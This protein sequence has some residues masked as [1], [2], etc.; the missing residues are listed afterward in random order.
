MKLALSHVEKGDYAPALELLIDEWQ[1]TRRPSVADA[2]D[3]VDR[4]FNLPASK[5][6][7]WEADAAATTRAAERGPLIRAI[8]PRTTNE[9]LT[10]VDVAMKWD[11]PRVGSLIIALL[12]EL[13]YSG[14]RSKVFWDS[15]FRRIPKLRDARFAL[16][17]PTL[18]KTWQVGPS[19]QTWLTNRLKKAATFHVEDV[20][21]EVLERIVEVAQAQI[22]ALAVSIG[23]HAGGV[24]GETL[25]A[26]VYANPTDDA[27]RLVYAD[28]LLE[29]ADPRGEFISLQLRAEKDRAAMKRE[30]E[31]LKAHKKEWLGSLAPVIGGDP[32][33]RRGFLAEATVKFRHQRDV[34]QAGSLPDWATLE[35]LVYGEHLVRDDQLEWARF[36]GPAMR[37]VKSANGPMAKYLLAPGDEPWALE[38]LETFRADSSHEVFRALMTTPR[39]ARL[40]SYSASGY[41]RSHWL[42]EAGRCPPTLKV[43]A[44]LGDVELMR[45]LQVGEKIASLETLVT[46]EY[47][48]AEYCWTRDKFGAFT[49][50][51][52]E[53]RGVPGPKPV[54][55]PHLVTP[56][57]RLP[58]NWLTFFDAK[59]HVEKTDEWVN[60][61]E[62][63]MTIGRAKIRG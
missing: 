4:A 42:E 14:D 33:F 32:V 41:A 44:Q 35:K 27:A 43:R 52:V 59:V 61:G 63:T 17:L 5:T 57:G 39:L 16:I 21:D 9:I 28:W 1:R 6:K 55:P 58:D 53:I 45:W 37:H 36:W 8:Q 22:R 18:P 23:D 30:R 60:A 24:S 38:E 10:A 15:V 3:V 19:M 7:T 34:E 11:D 50:L 31:L 2:I 54:A 62:E 47:A 46:R 12:T 20:A 13:R 56:L 48:N 26:D 51:T 49:R 25:I 29:R 40:R